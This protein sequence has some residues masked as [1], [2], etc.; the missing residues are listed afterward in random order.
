ME[1][2]SKAM[3]GVDE[4][5]EIFVAYMTTVSAGALDALQKKNWDKFAKAYNGGGYPP[6]YPAQMEKHYNEFK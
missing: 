4:Q 6:A 1:L 2:A 5:F 3:M